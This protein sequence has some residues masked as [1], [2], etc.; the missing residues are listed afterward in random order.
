MEFVQPNQNDAVSKIIKNETG[1]GKANMST[2]K[3]TNFTITFIGHSQSRHTVAFASFSANM[4]AQPGWLAT[5]SAE[6]VF[7]FIGLPVPLPRYTI[8]TSQA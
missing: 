7:I 8:L 5:A 2:T 4:P 1:A 3:R 6:T